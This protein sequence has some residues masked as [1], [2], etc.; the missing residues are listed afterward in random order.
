MQSRSQIWPTYEHMP[1]GASSV[2]SFTP[3]RQQLPPVRKVLR[4]LECMICRQALSLLETRTDQ[5]RYPYNVTDVEV[6]SP[7]PEPRPLPEVIPEVVRALYGE[8]SLAEQNGLM[9]GAAG[10][11]RAAVEAMCKERGAEGSNL[12]NRITALGA[13]GIDAE[14]IENLHE[15]RALGNYSLH[16]GVEFSSEEVADVAELLL[17]AFT[18]L[19]VQ[20]A[21]RARLR[22][23]RKSRQ[24]A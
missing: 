12:Y 21:E 11:Y 18:V 10:L 1:T 6:I 9:R 14:L 19:Y 23:A 20:P 13:K 8:G 5:G 3:V 24:Q 17:E 15:A 16:D 4:V 22:Q 2:P 7:R